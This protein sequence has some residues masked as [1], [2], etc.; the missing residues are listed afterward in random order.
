LSH[1]A[2][3]AIGDFLKSRF[4]GRDVYADMTRIRKAIPK[5]KRQVKLPKAPSACPTLWLSLGRFIT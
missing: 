5:L 3:L 1:T 2:N 4:K